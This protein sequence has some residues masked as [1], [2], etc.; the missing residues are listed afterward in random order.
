V[1]VSSDETFPRQLTT[2]KL[3]NQLQLTAE[4]TAAVNCRGILKLA[5][6]SC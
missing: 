1:A 2:E 3:K 6:V 4:E 5:T